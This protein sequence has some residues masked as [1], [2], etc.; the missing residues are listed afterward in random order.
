M[1][2]FVR[3]TGLFSLLVDHGRPRTRSLGMPVGGA[4]DRTALALGNALVGNLPAALALEVTLLGPTIEALQTTACVLFG[5][6]F[7]SEIN[8]SR[9]SVATTFTLEPGQVLRI[10]GTRSNARGY[11]CVAGGFEACGLLGSCSGIEPVR[12][13]ETLVCRAARIEPRALPFETS[14][15]G[16]GV[17]IS[18]KA[19]RVVCGPQHEWYSDDSLALQEY[20]V[21]S[22]SNRMGIRL[23]GKPLTRNPGELVSEAVAPGAVQVTNDGQLIILGVDGQTIGGYPKI[24]HVIRADLDRLGQL[25]PGE[26]V[27]F[28]YVSQEDALTAAKARAVFLNEWRTRLLAADRQPQYLGIEA[29]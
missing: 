21:T 6:A 8:G 7:Q 19:L 11:L 29:V 10:G 27:R 14:E 4:A 26:K 2:L 18:P 23:Q 22:A 17:A 1:S 15:G 12:V 24:A 25:R 16:H 13:G 20:E 3:E 28:V 5:A 9:I